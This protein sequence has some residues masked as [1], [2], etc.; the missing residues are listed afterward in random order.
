MESS[1][2][3]I[4]CRHFAQNPH[5]CSRKNKRCREMFTLLYT[6]SKNISRAV[7]LRCVFLLL[8]VTGSNNIKRFNDWWTYRVNKRVALGPL[9]CASSDGAAS[10]MRR[11]SVWPAAFFSLLRKR[12]FLLLTGPCLKSQTDRHISAQSQL[13]SSESVDTGKRLCHCLRH[14]PV[15]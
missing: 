7:I 6:V 9:G 15:F 1:Q 5:S 14:G 8:L 11:C 3:T 2:I 12:M 10:Y 13:H 4:R